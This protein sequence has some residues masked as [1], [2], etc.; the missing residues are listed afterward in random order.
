M[1]SVFVLYGGP[2]VE[3]QVSVNSAKA[4]INALDRTK[5]HVHPVYITE[6]GVWLRLPE[7]KEPF[8]TVEQ[9]IREPEGK[10]VAAS[11]AEFLTSH[12]FT[13][14]NTIFF[15]VLLLGVGIATGVQAVL[16]LL[17]S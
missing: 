4:V 6:E 11:L 17:T 2:S 8:D 13:D 7:S 1:K 15:A 10:S 12:D 14:G 5:Y 3:H 9:M 16:G